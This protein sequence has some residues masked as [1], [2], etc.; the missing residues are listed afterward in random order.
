VKTIPLTRGYVTRVD[1]ADYE[2]LSRYNWCSLVSTRRDGSVRCVYAVRSVKKAR[3]SHTLY[4]H[5]EILGCTEEV[6]HRDGD[7]LN[8]Q[9]ENLRPATGTQNHANERLSVDNTSGVKGVYWH[10]QK[11]KWHVQCRVGK[12]SRSG[13]LYSDINEAAR[14]YEKL[15]TSLWGKFA[16]PEVAP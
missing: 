12:T 4:M 6:D 11:G 9:R 16:R 13:G 2:G 5:R 7:G 15:A 3:K 1:D 14:A 10:K 8:N